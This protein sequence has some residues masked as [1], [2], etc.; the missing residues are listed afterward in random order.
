MAHVLPQPPRRAHSSEFS[1]PKLA[2]NSTKSVEGQT[3]PKFSPSLSISLPRSFAAHPIRA[4]STFSPQK[5]HPPPLPR[6][7][8][9][10]RCRRHHRQQPP[11][12]PCQEPPPSLPLRQHRMEMLPMMTNQKIANP[13]WHCWDRYSPPISIRNG[14]LHGS[15]GQNVPRFADFSRT[16]P[17]L[18]LLRMGN[19]TSSYLISRKVGNARPRPGCRCSK[20]E[21]R[22]TSLEN[23][24][25]ASIFVLFFSPCLSVL[26]CGGCSLLCASLC[27]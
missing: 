18:L 9:P 4:L 8:L 22:T 2:T 10:Q 1:T 12:P 7:H 27:A 11:P 13:R 26:L 21:T 25:R 19:S 15:E 3:A 5:T 20:N 17:S 24:H 14:V 6:R 16:I 23:Q